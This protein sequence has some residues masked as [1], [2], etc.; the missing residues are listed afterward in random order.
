LLSQPA[1]CLIIKKQKG[2]AAVVVVGQDMKKFHGQ[3]DLFNTSQ[4][5]RRNIMS[6]HSP[7]APQL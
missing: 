7:R 6:C 3:S 1:S 4:W 2:A 5:S